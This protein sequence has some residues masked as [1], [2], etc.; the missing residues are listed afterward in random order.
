MRYQLNI[1]PIYVYNNILPIQFPI[2]IAFRI[3]KI[4]LTEKDFVILLEKYNL[5]IILW[6]TYNKFST[7]CKP[8]ISNLIK[9]T[10][11]VFFLPLYDDIKEKQNPFFKKTDIRLLNFYSIWIKW[12]DISRYVDTCVSLCHF[13]T[14]STLRFTRHQ[15]KVATTSSL[16]F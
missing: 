4:S 16:C 14:L 9:S 3:V 5:Y 1:F 11:I 8:F 13:I 6:S 2:S 10:L 12:V 7:Q 15:S